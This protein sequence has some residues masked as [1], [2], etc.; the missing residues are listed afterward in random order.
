MGAKT[1]KNT[2]PFKAK[3]IRLISGRNSPTYSYNVSDIKSMPPE[4]LGTLVI[5][6][7]NERVAAL[8][9]KYK[10]LRTV[11]LMKGPN[12]NQITIFEKIQ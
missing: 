9:Q 4:E 8:Y 5:E 6:I 2:N 7:W 1:V 11:V 12:L 10:T 3:K